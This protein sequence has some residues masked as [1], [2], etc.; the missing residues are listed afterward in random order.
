M[1]LQ[2]PLSISTPKRLDTGHVLKS[3]KL[4][5]EVLINPSLGQKPGRCMFPLA[6]AL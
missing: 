5:G 1:E 3:S 2:A 6:M 4:L